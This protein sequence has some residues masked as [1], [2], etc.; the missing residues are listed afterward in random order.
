[1]ANIHERLILGQPNFTSQGS[2]ATILI[3]LTKYALPW[4]MSQQFLYNKA[5]YQRIA[6]YIAKSLA[7]PA[8]LY[9]PML[10]SHGDTVL[11]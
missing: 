8:V 7:K 2:Y 9:Q 3:P 4:N 6:I 11:A 10:V 1:M 5:S